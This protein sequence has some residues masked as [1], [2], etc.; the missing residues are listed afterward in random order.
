MQNRLN[1]FRILFLQQLT[2]FIQVVDLV[3]PS[4]FHVKGIV[5][6]HGL[7]SSCFGGDKK[8]RV[9][10]QVDFT[11]KPTK[12]SL[13]KHSCSFSTVLVTFLRLEQK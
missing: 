10:N 7:A 6:A 5:N 11:E 2:F 8:T 13:L 12:F 3:I 4:S 1:D 9:V